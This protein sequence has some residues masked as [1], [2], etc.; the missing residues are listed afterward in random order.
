MREKY[1]LNM[2][3]NVDIWD[4][5]NAEKEAIEAIEPLKVAAG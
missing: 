1:W 3:R 2:Q 4:S 5:F